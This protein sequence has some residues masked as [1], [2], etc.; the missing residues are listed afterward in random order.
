MENKERTTLYYPL[1]I[2]YFS[3]LNAANVQKSFYLSCKKTI[4]YDMNRQD[5][6]NRLQICS[7]LSSLYFARGGFVNCLTVSI[8]LRKELNLDNPVQAERSS[9]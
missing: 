6:N 4:D 5:K 2:V 3:F 9:G 7:G 8:K 1:Y